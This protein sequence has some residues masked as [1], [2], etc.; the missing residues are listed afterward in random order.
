MSLRR[1]VKSPAGAI[2]PRCSAGSSMQISPLWR[3]S[4]VK[5]F[6]F[7]WQATVLGKFFY[8]DQFM[9]KLLVFH[10]RDCCV[11]R[12]KN[13]VIKQATD[14]TPVVWGKYCA[15]RHALSAHPANAGRSLQICIWGVLEEVTRVLCVSED[16][17]IGGMPLFQAKSCCHL[18]Q[19]AVI[20]HYSCHLSPR[21]ATCNY[22]ILPVTTCKRLI[23]ARL[24]CKL[25]CRYFNVLFF[26][27]G[28]VWSAVVVRREPVLLFLLPRFIGSRPLPLSRN[29]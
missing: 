22:P 4:P 1:L 6:P 24:P 8:L 2:V 21:A 14:V 15:W 19:N 10:G 9:C 11:G 26:L 18:S 7:Y 29:R 20:C 23:T 13:Y 27:R 28:Y 16:P 5:W 25:F 3:Q 17:C 12:D